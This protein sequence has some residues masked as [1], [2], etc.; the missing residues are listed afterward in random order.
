[1]T[2]QD[3]MIIPDLLTSGHLSHKVD[4]DAIAILGKLDTDEQRT[5]LRYISAQVEPPLRKKYVGLENRL[6]EKVA[7]IRRSSISYGEHEIALAYNDELIKRIKYMN[8][9][10][11]KK[12][13]KAQVGSV[14]TKGMR[15]ML[16]AAEA[17]ATI[18]AK[19]IEAKAA[20]Q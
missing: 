15:Y 7:A 8:W 18:A 10:L 13:K 11:Q 20:R 5:R 3:P 12:S 17:I 16:R 2:I 6:Y 4:E 1:M 19:E 9:L 14:S